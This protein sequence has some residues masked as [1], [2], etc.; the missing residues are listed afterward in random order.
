[1]DE[2]LT[3]Y[4]LDLQLFADGDTGEKTEQATPR[5]REEARKKGQVFKSTDLNSAVILLTGSA[6]LFFTFPYMAGQIKAFTAL[7]LLHR[8]AANFDGSYAYYMFMEVMLLLARVCFPVL[9]ATFVSALLVSFLQVGVVFSGEAMAPKLERIN[10]IEGFK[11]IFSKRAL[12]ELTKSLIKVAVTGYV[13]YTVLRNNYAVFPHFVDMEL[14]ATLMTLRDLVFEIAMKVG[15]VFVIIGVIDYLYQWY[16]YD[17]SLKMSKFE[18]KQEYK[19][20]EG[21]PAIKSRQRQIQRDM[22]MR[23]MM[24]EVPRADVVITNPTHFAIALKYEA[25]KMQA[26]I[27][28]A[29]GQDY[30]ALRIKEIAAEHRIATVENPVLARTLFNSTKIGDVVP[31]DLYQAI[32]E[33]LAFVYRQKKVA[34]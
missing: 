28:V 34:L 14:G 13:V 32:A 18:I 31:E 29:K 24:S 21:D 16:E 10:P 3:W 19:Q 22:A 33:I 2:K 23:R 26:P 11:R 4:P 27:V 15:I 9:L 30:V 12:M 20:T 1:M 6:T 8:G 25:E 5:R 7:Y 17:N